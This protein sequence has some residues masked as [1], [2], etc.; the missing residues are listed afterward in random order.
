MT[1]KKNTTVEVLVPVSKFEE[2][3]FSYVKDETRKRTVVMFEGRLVGRFMGF[4]DSHQG[5]NSLL[6]GEDHVVIVVKPVVKDVSVEE[7][8]E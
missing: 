3:G 5:N 4:Y 8:F 6:L 1:I 7:V 2:L